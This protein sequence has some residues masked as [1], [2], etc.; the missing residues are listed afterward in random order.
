MALYGETVPMQAVLGTLGTNVI[1]EVF[2]VQGASTKFGQ[3]WFK[4][5][6]LSVKHL[7]AE[8]DF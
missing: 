4:C 6:N 7:V 8:Y 5:P 2:L 3:K 1:S